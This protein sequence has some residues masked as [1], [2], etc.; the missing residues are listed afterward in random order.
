MKKDISHYDLCKVTAER[1]LKESEIVL[2][3]YQNAATGEFPDV[4][5][6]NGAY[7][8]L[9]EIKVD[10]QDFK[11]DGQKDCRTEY[12]VKYFGT[13]KYYKN[14]LK[15]VMFELPELQ[16]FIKEAPHLGRQRYYVCPTGM[17]QPEEIKNGFG[18]YYYNGKFSLKKKSEQFKHDMFAEMNIMSHAF[19]KYANGN[20]ENILIKKY[21]R[22]FK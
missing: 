16:E 8:K 2:F 5:C 6:F 20:M 9:F 4:L 3:E 18:L 17:I 19:R 22:N 13:F 10:Y 21:D 12:K 11:K 1:F 15:S 14:I 7:T